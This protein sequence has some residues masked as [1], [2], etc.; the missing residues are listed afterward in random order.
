MKKIYIQPPRHPPPSL[1]QGSEILEMEISTN[2]FRNVFFVNFLFISIDGPDSAFDISWDFHL[3][4][5]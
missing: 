1:L 5:R 2:N 4:V 3:K